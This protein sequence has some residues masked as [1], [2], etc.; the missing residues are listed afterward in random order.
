MPLFAPMQNVPLRD[1]YYAR[2]GTIFPNKSPTPNQTYREHI[3]GGTNYPGVLPLVKIF[4]QPIREILGGALGEQFFSQACAAAEYHDIGKLVEPWQAVLSKQYL[5]G[6]REYPHYSNPHELMGQF[7]LADRQAYLASFCVRHHGK[8]HM[9]NDARF[10]KKDIK[11]A[12]ASLTKKQVAEIRT[13]MTRHMAALG[14]QATSLLDNYTEKTTLTNCEMALYIRFMMSVIEDADNT[15]VGCHY[16]NDLILD[17][18]DTRWEE[19]YRQFIV[20]TDEMRAASPRNDRNRIRTGMFFQL[21]NA[22]RIKVI[23]ICPGLVGTGKTE[24]VLAHLLREAME[25]GRRHIIIV[26]P[27]AHL[28]HQLAKRIRKYL[29]LPGED[30]ERVVIEHHHEVDYDNPALRHASVRWAGPIIVTSSVQFFETLAS[31]G[32]A[33]IQKL[34]ELVNSSVMFDEAH[35]SIPIRFARLC[36][37]WMR[38]LSKRFACSFVLSSGTLAR[39]WEVKELIPDDTDGVQNLLTQTLLDDMEK[40]DKRNYTPI[41]CEAKRLKGLTD[42]VLGHEG[43]RLVIM[44]TRKNAAML[45]EYLRR[46]GHEVAH[47]SSV[48]CP[49]DKKTISDEIVRRLD[50]GT[51]CADFTIVATSCF[52]AGVDISVRSGFCE[53]S[54]A[55]DFE[56]LLGR[57]NRNWEIKEG[58]FCCKFTVSTKDKYFNRN[59]DMDSPKMVE[60]SMRD[61]NLIGELNKTDLS[62]EA[63]RRLVRID[64]SIREESEA[65]YKE[66]L[67]LHFQTVRELFRIIEDVTVDVI[68]D[69]E[70]VMRLRNGENVKWQEQNQHCVQIRK[71]YISKYTLE[72]LLPGETEVFVWPRKYDPHFLGYMEEE[73]KAEVERYMKEEK[74]KELRFRQRYGM[75]PDTSQ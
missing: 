40:N 27:Y 12:I 11:K 51:S 13:A 59:P 58:G 46:A 26:A 18:I 15:N 24:A 47:L 7:I 31:N 60:R 68:V 74:E 29:V 25:C 10:Y 73:I 22:D 3:L 8:E 6:E 16:N 61:E 2:S 38:V 62:T 9:G 30:P 23:R 36:W 17:R 75:E 67:A 4:A 42:L 45:A 69:P 72:P 52:K 55:L 70:I 34:H 41:S 66:E 20:K 71:S 50:S 28:I 54:G 37:K 49:R 64:G 48:L 39:I 1:I 65:I 35:E 32:G 33:K 53:A 21:L 5:F 14:S 56:Q 19:R 43:P 44:N 63:I 57:V